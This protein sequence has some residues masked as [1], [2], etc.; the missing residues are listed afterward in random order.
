MTPTLQLIGNG[1]L[2]AVLLVWVGYRQTTWRVVDPAR[3]LRLPALLGIAGI[4]ILV[5]GRGTVAL[6]GVGFAMLAIELVLSLG[7]GAL[8]GAIS[9]FRAMTP[10][11]ITAY[12]AGR[13]RRGST[14]APVSLE[15]RTGWF[16]LA[17]WIVLI[18]ARIG[19]GVLAHQLGATALAST[20][21]ILLMVAANRAARVGVIIARSSRETVLSVPGAQ[22]RTAA[23]LSGPTRTE[24][25]SI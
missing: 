11:A 3:M 23:R 21:V 7:V 14:G 24:P 16:G 4:A 20:G 17:L 2:I 6:T 1:L 15:A 22:L 19:I 12:G 9:R 13:N 18:A 5:N 25:D 10:E 8:M